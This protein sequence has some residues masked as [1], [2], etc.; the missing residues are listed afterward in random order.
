MNTATI[1]WIVV[2]AVGAIAASFASY[3]VF[4]IDAVKKWLLF[5]VTQAESE[6][7]AGTGK[8]KLAKV[9]DMFI[10]RFPK[11]HVIVSYKL[12]SKLVDVALEEMRKMLEG[13]SRI[14]DIVSKN[15]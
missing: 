4:G 7:G 15:E 8:L 12:F 1:I 9:Y 5:A 2:G 6:F 11:L 13:N 14:L 10:T 3:K